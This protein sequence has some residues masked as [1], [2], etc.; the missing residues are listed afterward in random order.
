MTGEIAV[1]RTNGYLQVEDI[2]P[3]LRDLILQAA[4]RDVTEVEA[5]TDEVPWRAPGLGPE[6]R[7]DYRLLEVN[8]HA[9]RECD[10]LSGAGEALSVEFRAEAVRLVRELGPVTGWDG[11]EEGLVLIL[12]ETVPEHIDGES[13]DA[14]GKRAFVFKTVPVLRENGVGDEDILAVAARTTMR[15]RLSWA[16]SGIMKDAEIPDKGEAIRAAVEDA[17]TL[18]TREFEREYRAPKVAPAVYDEWEVASGVV[19][20]VYPSLDEDQRRVLNTALKHKQERVVLDRQPVTVA[21]VHRAQAENDWSL[22][23][24]ATLPQDARIALA[25][26]GA[27]TGTV[28]QVA[29]AMGVTESKAARL[30]TML[31][32]LGLVELE[33]GGVVKV[34]GG[35]GA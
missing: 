5:G 13:G 17:K 12:D 22:L 19:H 34:K 14:R 4:E 11:T 29:A 7:M 10:L 27:G 33:A 31:E 9:A 35:S 18:S 6:Q 26:V 23:Y 24:E 8:L 21:M 25:V 20:R 32:G 3:R 30:A 1:C 28:A 2:L 16:V 15:P